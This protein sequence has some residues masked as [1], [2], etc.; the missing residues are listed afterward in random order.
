MPT[1][2]DKIAQDVQPYNRLPVLSVVSAHRAGLV[3]RTGDMPN[4]PMASA[5]GGSDLSGIE[6]HR[7]FSLNSTS[8]ELSCLIFKSTGKED[9]TGKMLMCSYSIST[10]CFTDDRLRDFTVQ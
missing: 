8:C 1:K 6:K 10:Q 9:I 2:S 5:H 4:G 3:D 7:L